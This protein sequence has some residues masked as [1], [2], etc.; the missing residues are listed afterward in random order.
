MRDACGNNPLETAIIE[1]QD[2][3]VD[4]LISSYSYAGANIHMRHRGM[5]IL[6]YAIYALL[7]AGYKSHTEVF[8]ADQI[9]SKLRQMGAHLIPW[10]PKK[11]VE[12]LNYAVIIN[13]AKMVTQFLNPNINVN[14]KGRLFGY[15]A[16][17]I[18]VLLYRNDIIKQLLEYILTRC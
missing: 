5:S 18:A 15:P 6:N 11:P 12:A 16:L 8:R 1:H 17:M 9:V 14:E 4:E 2:D 13:D 7:H 10:A 3:T